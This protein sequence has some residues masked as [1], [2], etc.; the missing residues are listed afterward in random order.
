MKELIKIVKVLNKAHGLLIEYGTS[1]TL[2]Y[3]EQID[4]IADD[5]ERYAEEIEA[6]GK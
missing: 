2:N 6:Q 4:G 5:L 3:S 1:T